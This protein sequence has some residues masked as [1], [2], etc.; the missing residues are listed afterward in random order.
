MLSQIN[1][2]IPIIISKT[3]ITMKRKK[4]IKKLFILINSILIFLILNQISFGYI[5]TKDR[6]IFSEQDT[7]LFDFSEIDTR[8]YQLE[9]TDKQLISNDLVE[10]RN[11]KYR[12]LKIIKL[13]GRKSKTYQNNYEIK[14]FSQNNI[15]NKLSEHLE[16][17][18]V[19]N[20]FYIIFI[21]KQICY[22]KK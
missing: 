6:E 3:K 13:E 17:N 19:L 14:V 2:K 12:N 9:Y 21:R 16:K 15:N 5:D 11:I 1:S 20:F 4:L 18:K 8:F 22:Y 7:G 10:K